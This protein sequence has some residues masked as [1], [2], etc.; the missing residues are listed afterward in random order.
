MKRKKSHLLL[1]TS[2]SIGLITF[3]LLA[4]L[5]TMVSLISI[6]NIDKNITII[7]KETAENYAQVIKNFLQE[8]L[9][10]ARSLKSVYQGIIQNQNEMEISRNDSNIILKS[11][12]EDHPTYLG[13]YVLFEPNKFDGKDDLF[14]NTDYHDASGRYIPYWYLDEAG[15]GA[16]DLLMD[17]EEDFSGWYQE[18]KRQNKEAI[19]D[20]FIYPIDGVDVLMTS[21]TVPIKDESG[22]FIGITGIDIS[23]D[24]IAQMTATLKIEE[25][26][27]A[28]ITIFSQNGIVA[29]S[30]NKDWLGLPI[31]EIIDQS[32]Y[33]DLI[34]S[35]EDFSTEIKQDGVLYYTYGVPFNIGYTESNWMITFSIS[36]NEL[37]QTINNMIIL[38]IAIGLIFLIILLGIVVVIV[39]SITTSVKRITR[40]ASDVSR[41][42]LTKEMVL[43][44]KDEIG[45]MGETLL[46]MSDSLSEIVS[47][48]RNSAIKVTQRSGE[49]SSSAQNLSEGVADQ[50]ASAE[51]VSASMEEM[52][53][54][55]EQ[56]TNNA[57]KTES[58]SSQ[59][60]LDA[61]K[62]GEAVAEAVT[63]MQQIAEKIS[64]IE[65]I[66]R[67][68]NLLALNAAIEAAR[69]GEAGK[70]F[71][72]VAS[73]V[74]K[75]AE[76]SQ[77]SANEIS[78]LSS[79]TVSVA[80]Q[81]G[82]L[83]NQLLP[84]IKE[85]ASLV[86]EISHASEEQNSG[87]EQ[88]NRALLQLDSVIQQ[89][90]SSSK[91]MA[92]TAFDLN[93]EA[94]ALSSMMSFFSLK[95]NKRRDIS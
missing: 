9:D 69:A 81:A 95:K 87:V 11:F 80:V 63:A 15:K 84:R 24:K 75:L 51:E 42:D 13:A 55:I 39:R 8:P 12:I 4:L 66:A 60:S 89:N 31:E 47:N 68:T 43:N 76:R 32:E 59:V 54:N 61:E 27:D 46:L 30:H 7:T 57:K 1:K 29:G 74:R 58:L 62:S 2:L 33:V 78:T 26:E 91:Q 70:G 19:Q 3:F 92:S 25:F 21:L 49:I 37:Y 86:Q 35:G 56:T 10:E 20:P 14:K 64:I 38:F 77:L 23:I 72:V 6:N 85:T 45:I 34:K 65:E 82:K 52:A 93:K 40:L 16:L 50:A 17:Y 73:E 90:A 71:A 36:R 18:P 94:E 53:A 41:G 5:L 28:F 44:R 48:V 83:L 22:N 67:Q 79:S 88:I